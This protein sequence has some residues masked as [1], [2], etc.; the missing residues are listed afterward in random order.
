MPNHHCLA[1]FLPT[2]IELHPDDDEDIYGPESE[3]NM[4]D[5]ED[6]TVRPS[7]S[8]N[9]SCLTRIDIT[10]GFSSVTLPP[11]IKTVTRKGRTLVYRVQPDDTAQV[12]TVSHSSAT[13]LSTLC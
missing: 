8:I 3:D 10:Q 1:C 2:C 4:N 7:L 11:I 6:N 13:T 12:Q 9:S 5:E